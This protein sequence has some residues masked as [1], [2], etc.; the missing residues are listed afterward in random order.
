MTGRARSSYAKLTVLVGGLL[1]FAV[2]CA[3]NAPQDT[4]KPEG[5][6]ACQIFHL[7]V[8]VFVVAGVVGVLVMGAALFIVVKFRERKDDDDRRVPRADPRQLQGRDRL[9]HPPALILVGVAVPTVVTIFDLARSRRPDALQVE[10][11]GQ[12]W[13]W[14]YH[15]DIDDD[16]DGEVDD[17]ITANELVIPV[18]RQVAL[19]I[20]SNDVI[21]SFWIPAL[22][23]KKDAVPGACTRWKLE[24]DE[25]RRVPRPVHR[26]LR[27]LPRQHAHGRAPCEPDDFEAWAEQPAAARRSPP[28]TRRP[29]AGWNGR[30][31][32]SARRCH[33]ID[34]HERRP[35]IDEAE[36]AR[37]PDRS[38]TRCPA[39]PRTSPTS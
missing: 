27:P 14:E 30:S 39:S 16:G 17:I 28:P 13:W 18:G 19:R 35:A 36:R 33:L 38:S 6:E 23:G 15:Y 29:S 3:S 26:V 25:A 10:V 9:D 11:N 22:N 12:Q 32:A 7:I 21:H 2:G 34:G 20:T 5:P 1:F 24:A 8:P 4:F 37:E 31:P